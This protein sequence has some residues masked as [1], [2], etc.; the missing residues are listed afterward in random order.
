MKGGLYQR[1][2]SVKGGLFGQLLW[3]SSVAFCYDLLTWPPVIAFWCTSLALHLARTP[4]SSGY[5]QN[6]WYA[7]YCNAFLFSYCKQMK[8]GPR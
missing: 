2:L 7:S 8:F 1:G 3:P 4:T 6:K 5:H